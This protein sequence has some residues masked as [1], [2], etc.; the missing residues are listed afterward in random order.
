MRRLRSLVRSLLTVLLLAALFIVWAY[1]EKFGVN[2]AR[3]TRSA[4]GGAV[5]V[6]DGDTLRIDHVEHRLYG[7]D[8]P[9]YNQICKDAA[10]R[11]WPC[12]Q[13]A[14]AAMAALVKGHVI[15]CEERATDK[16][17]RIVATCKDET[18]RDLAQAMAEAGLAIGFGGFGTSPYQDQADAAQAAKTGI[19]QGAFD[20][21]QVWRA[22]H[23]HYG[24][25]PVNPVVN[26]VV[27]PAA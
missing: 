8:A 13:A 25:A 9:E 16:Y 6:M 18:G 24:V 12:G 1:P 10:G 17:D 7:V 26:P 4:S 21:P 20:E 15:S 5:I 23:P 14:R 19:W 27:N 11:D 2:I 22:A 3:P